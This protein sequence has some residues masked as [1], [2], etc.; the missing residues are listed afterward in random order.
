MPDMMERDG[1]TEIRADVRDALPV[2]ALTESHCRC[3]PGCADR[4]MDD[5]MQKPRRS[6]DAEQDDCDRAQDRC[7]ESIP[8]LPL[9]QPK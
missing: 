8:R 2:I 7:R 4:G 1:G 5:V 3:R 9:Y 6:Q